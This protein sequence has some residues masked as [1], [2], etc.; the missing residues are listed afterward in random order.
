MSTLVLTLPLGTPGPAAEYS[1]TLTA[2]G[3]PAPRHASTTA[4]LLPDPGRAGEIVPSL[5]E[6]QYSLDHSD[7]LRRVQSQ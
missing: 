4:A 1:Y 5:V 6:V 7:Y 3:H 2:D